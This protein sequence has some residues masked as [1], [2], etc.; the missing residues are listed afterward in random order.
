[1]PDTRCCNAL[2]RLLSVSLIAFTLAPGVASAADSALEEALA[3]AVSSDDPDAASAVVTRIVELIRE[4]R[5]NDIAEIDDDALDHLLP[6]LPPAEG[7]EL[8]VDLSE[9]AGRTGDPERQ[10]RIAAIGDSFIAERLRD[11]NDGLSMA[12]NLGYGYL[13]AARGE[14]AF[15]R[16]VAARNEAVSMGNGEDLAGLCVTAADSFLWFGFK[17]L[18]YQFYDGC[19]D[20]ELLNR[21]AT[22]ARSFFWHN[23]ALVLRDRGLFEKA[24]SRHNRAL[25]ELAIQYGEHS[26]EVRD[27]YDGMAQTALA[28]GKTGAAD[29]MAGLAIETAKTGGTDNGDDY[30]RLIN[31]AAAVKRALLRYGEAEALDREA[32]TWRRN[33]LD[34]GNPATYTSWYNLTLD[35]M[36]ELKWEKA[37]QSL[38]AMIAAAPDPSV[39]TYTPEKLALFQQYLDARLDD[40]AGR[41][42]DAPDLAAAIKANA[43]YEL[44]YGIENLLA[45]S[46]IRARDYERAYGMIAAFDRWTEDALAPETPAR[47]NARLELAAAEMMTGR[48]AAASLRAL[49]ADM[50]NWVREQSMSGSYSTAV[51]SRHMADSLLALL[52][53]QA[54]ADED[55]APTFAEAA[56]LWKTFERPAD[57]ALSEAVAET[58]NANLKEAVRRYRRNTGRFLEYVRSAPVTEAIAAMNRDLAAEQRTL[59]ARLIGAGLP[60]A[61][62][63]RDRVEVPDV[64]NFAVKPGDVLVD[65]IVIDRWEARDLSGYPLMKS[66]YGVVYRNDAPIAVHLLGSYPAAAAFAGTVQNAVILE[67]LAEW[68]STLSAKRLFLVSDGFL[69]QSDLTGLRATVDGPRLGEAA[70]VYLLSRR[71]AYLDRDRHAGLE[72]GDTVTL[73]GGLF[74]DE[75]VEE[76]ENYLAGS[77]REVKDIGGLAEQGGAR[78]T[79]FTG[80]GATELAIAAA[81]RQSNILHLATHGFFTDNDARPYS[82]FNAGI[83]LSEPVYSGDISDSYDNIA[84]AQEI[85]DWDLLDTRLVVLSACETGLGAETPIDAVRGLPMALARAGAS[86]ALITLD[87]I[88]DRQTASIMTRFYT[89]VVDD[90]LSYAEAF[91]QTKRDIWSGGIEGVSPSVADA[92]V[93]YEN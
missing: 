60:Q 10:D 84:Y 75:G 15:A 32:L 78:V 79:T 73:A 25:Q 77:L 38:E 81:A 86:R 44:I 41:P 43:P 45:G 51:A 9:S 27:A 46:A 66:I 18:S 65:F 17:D 85:L 26:R 56:N 82:L 93:F 48:P 30:Y 61:A 4:G 2:L 31:N 52:A 7:A 49:N 1:M 54:V 57:I 70:D 20:T 12:I 22:P 50:F 11:P 69:Y 21:T 23:Y 33:H 58:G 83:E 29:V 59:N 55:F 5:F 62:F 74:Y 6:I 64:T 36:G 53:E 42:F 34:S 63:V 35:L 72:A 28:A 88:P 91:L 71:D 87:I 3:Q 24:L 76:S 90:K 39:L 47:Y 8:I 14:E 37:A 13:G 68:L 19:D 89:Y 67:E 80:D 92:F 40:A 16:L